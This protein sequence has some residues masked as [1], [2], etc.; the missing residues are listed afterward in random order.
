MINN[1]QPKAKDKQTVSNIINE[2]A[3]KGSIY[4][5]I[6][7]NL[8]APHLHYKNDLL[9][10]ITIDYLN[11]ATSVAKAINKGYFKYYFI[12]TV[13]NQVHS[14]TSK[15]YKEVKLTSF[16][17]EE[18]MEEFIDVEDLFG[19]EYKMEQEDKMNIVK[20]IRK[21][22]KI[23]YFESECIRL[24]FDEGMTYRAIAKEYEVNHTLIFHVIKTVVATYKEQLNKKYI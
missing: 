15:F 7:D 1:K 19:M 16:K 13:K 14:K 22:T 5:E 3:T 2:I 6:I 24:Y 9:S 11:N 17:V 20:Q 23:S 21:T 18:F 10:I 4:N 12:M 8:I